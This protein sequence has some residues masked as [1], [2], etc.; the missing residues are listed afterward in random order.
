MGRPLVA[1]RYIESGFNE[2]GEIRLDLD[3][4]PVLKVPVLAL[5]WPASY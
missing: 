2:R 3:R 4:K 5:F 1:G